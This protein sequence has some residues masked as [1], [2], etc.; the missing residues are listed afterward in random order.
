MQ[1]TSES[2]SIVITELSSDEHAAAGEDGEGA[3]GERDR[4]RDHASGRRAAGRGAA[5][6]PPAARPARSSSAIPPAGR[7][8]RWR[9]PTASPPPA[10]GPGPRACASSA[11]HRLAH[12]RRPAVRGSRLRRGPCAAPGRSAADR[13][14]VPGRDHRRRRVAGAAPATSRGP[15]RS[16]APAGPAQQD[17]ER[18]GVAEVAFRQL[19]ALIGGGPGDAQRE[20]R[21]LLLD[22]S[23]STPRTAQPSRTTIRPARGRRCL[24]DR[25]SLP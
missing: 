19:L 25:K 17:D 24:T 1:T 16:T 6:A 8:R 23:P 13:A 12:R 10:A 5:A 4:R 9:S 18:R 11:G 21:E 14:A 20:R 3:E 15:C 22:P 2:A 7:G